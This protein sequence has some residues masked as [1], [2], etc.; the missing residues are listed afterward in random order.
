MQEIQKRELEEFIQD[1]DQEMMVPQKNSPAQLAAQ[2]K[3]EE[4]P[5]E[6]DPNQQ[7][8]EEKPQSPLLNDNSSSAKGSAE[9]A[10]NVVPPILD[11]AEIPDQP[12]RISVES[13]K[14]S[15]MVDNGKH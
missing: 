1:E 14:P 10:A 3:N 2:Q 7:P 4:A 8:G 6:A 13:I 11:S 5:K 12:Q 15:Q 9:Q